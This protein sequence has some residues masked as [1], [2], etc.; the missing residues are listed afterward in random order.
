MRRLITVFLAA[1]ALL[2]A[3]SDD[4]GS[5]PLQVTDQLTSATPAP[6]PEPRTEPAGTVVPA[7]ATRDVTLL[8]E[9]HTLALAAADQPRIELFDTQDPRGTPRIVQLPAPA[10]SLHPTPDGDTL[11]AALPQADTVVRIDLRN[12]R[13]SQRIDVPGDPADALE[14][15]S[16][17]FVS[18]PGED[19][20]AILRDGRIQQRVNGFPGADDLVRRGSTVVVLD[21]LTTSLTP[22]EISSGDKQ[23]ALRAGEGATNAVAD[24]F[25][26]V[27][28][29]DTRGEEI[30]AFA[31]EPLIMKQ[32]Y[33]VTG[34]P[35]GL[36]F[37]PRRDLAWVTLTARNQLVG[38]DVAGG[39]PREVHRLPTVRQ[40]ESTAVNPATGTVYIASATGDGLQV[41]RN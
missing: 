7:P 40:P 9:H 20:V 1:A 23:P 14:V 3:C 24:E 6:A 17:L 4:S 27:L 13:I 19:D 10:N 30:M 11:L 2:T 22:V 39:E 21:R 37:A 18:R 26:R 15:G 32:R 35:Y 5:R 28:A 38:Y 36:A 31:A 16:R 12:A 33:P 25:G 41:V 8:P 29:I 34:S